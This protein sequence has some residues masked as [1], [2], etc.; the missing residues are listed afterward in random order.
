MVFCERIVRT[1]ESRTVRT[2]LPCF[3]EWSTTAWC[4]TASDVTAAWHSSGEGCGHETDQSFLKGDFLGESCVCG[5]DPRSNSCPN[6][7]YRGQSRRKGEVGGLPP[8]LGASH[9]LP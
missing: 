5:K 9:S 3:C 4:N 8:A 1:R 7:G 2:G 6:I